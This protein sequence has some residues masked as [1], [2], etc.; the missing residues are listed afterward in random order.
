MTTSLSRAHEVIVVD[1]SES[2][3]AAVQSPSAF[4]SPHSSTA[5]GGPLPPPPPYQLQSSASPAAPMLIDDHD[6][7]S[8]DSDVI[9]Q[10]SRRLH[11]PHA[12]QQYNT[13]TH[14]HPHPSASHPF[15]PALPPRPGSSIGSFT[16]RL[17][18]LLPSTSPTPSHPSTPTHGASP[19]IANPPSLSSSSPPTPQ[20]KRQ[21]SSSSLHTSP[22]PSY[23][24]ATSSSA[25]SSSS[26]AFPL[27]SDFSEPHAL[28]QSDEAFARA[29]QE[30]E[31][32]SLLA[33]RRA[34]DQRA[35]AESAALLSSE[36]TCGVC[37]V[38]LG[39]DLVLEVGGAGG[40]G[41]GHRVCSDCL[42]AALLSNQ[43][44]VCLCPVAG[45][46]GAVD[47]RLMRRVLTEEELDGVQKK[48]MSAF[49]AASSSNYVQCPSCKETF[50]AVP[51]HAPPTAPQ[52]G[53]RTPPEVGPDGAPL[54]TAALLHRSQH[55]Y[56]CGGC[57]VNFCS[58]CSAVPY[59]LGYTC[60][61]WE[62]YNNAVHCRYCECALPP[63]S[64]LQAGL[65]SSTPA[66]ASS[67]SSMFARF[68]RSKKEASAAPAVVQRPS[69]VCL[70]PECQE[71]AAVACTRE[72][73]PCHHQCDGIKGEKV[74]LPCLVA[75]CPQNVSRVSR[76]DWCNICWYPHH[77]AFTPSHSPMA[78]CTALLTVLMSMVCPLCRTEMLGQAPCLQLQCGHVFHLT[79]MGTKLGKGWPSARI[80]FHFLSCPLCNALVQ[81]PALAQTMQ[82]W[83]TLREVVRKKASERLVWEGCQNDKEVQKGGKYEGRKDDYA[84]DLFAY[85][86]CY[87]CKQPYFGGRRHCEEA[88]GGG[89]ADEKKWDPKELVCGGCVASDPA[90][91]A[92]G[93][94]KHGKEFLEYKCKWSQHD[95][96]AH[97]SHTHAH[98]HN[99]SPPPSSPHALPYLYLPAVACSGAATSPR[100]TGQLKDSAAH[101]AARHG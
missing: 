72:H 48:A 49:L 90:N 3:E 65:A 34:R 54:S 8:D 97:T 99:S 31:E 76:E 7:D 88:A 27:P 100:G 11:A 41:C 21:K 64:Q 58:G 86:E 23:P 98:T 44:A 50:E 73:L 37:R 89:G 79:C 9:E 14:S 46:S 94:P 22:P 56:R 77:A 16:Q 29:L 101:T 63:Q 33:A 62:E 78:A 75:D 40:G 60:K 67:S 20:S 26:P 84:M 92:A 15:P 59:H 57:D 53:G 32:R 95:A 52:D 28:P 10:P 13:A 5:S 36:G 74:C 43:A 85:Y 61:E 81:H 51:S 82:P 71:K 87:T 66:S 93:C 4:K 19:P 30:E 83:L 91:A 42:R 55:R 47:E 39:P 2:K 96:H 69:N 25:S 1:D 35:A 38:T 70:K 24:I 18:S 6:S 68:T 45:C 17:F 12:Q 80:T